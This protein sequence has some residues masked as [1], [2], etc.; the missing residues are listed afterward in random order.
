MSIGSRRGSD[1]TR[2]SAGTST[3]SGSGGR[4]RTPASAAAVTP[5]ST[6]CGPAAR[7]ATHNCWSRVSRPLLVTTMPRQIDRQHP[8]RTRPRTVPSVNSRVAW[9]VVS[10]P[11]CSNASHSNGSAFSAGSTLTTRPSLRSTTR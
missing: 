5:A 1:L 8:E 3:C 11:A 7:T 6:A 9:P 10:T 4:P 2:R